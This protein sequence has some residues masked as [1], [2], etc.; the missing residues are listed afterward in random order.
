MIHLL[1]RRFVAR[2]A[3]AALVGVWA[4]GAGP[5]AT[6]QGSGAHAAK[7][8]HIRTEIREAILK[9][10]LVGASVGIAQHGTVIW[11]EGLGWADRE[12][13]IPAT[14]DTTY[15]LASIS[16]TFTATG[17]MILK[18]RGRIGL[19]DPVEK[20]LG[21]AQLTAYRGSTAD[22]TI[23]RLLN[24][25]AGL[26]S[27]YQFFYVDQPYRRPP[28]E[29]SIRR[30]GMLV[31]APG[32]RHT[33]SNFGYGILDHVIARVSGQSY[34]DFMRQEVF[35][36]L[37]MT[38]SSIDI[39]PGLD[40]YVAQRYETDGT[41]I[42]FYDFDHPGASAVYASA[43]DLLRF[44]MFHLKNRLPDQR[45]ILRD[46]T[47]DLMQADSVP[48]GTENERRALGWR[49]EENVG[50][51]RNV[52]HAGGMPGVNTVLRLVPEQNLAVVVLCNYRNSLYGELAD[53][54]VK[55]LVSDYPVRKPEPF[56]PPI[57]TPF[58]AT[59]EL[60][61]AWEGELKAFDVTM[62]VRMT[63]QPDHDIHMKL[64]GGLETLLNEVRFDGQV[65]SA[66]FAG[67]IPSEDIDR[68][69]HDLALNVR[70][71][72]SEMTGTVTA[73]TTTPRQYYSL[74]TWVRLARQGPAVSQ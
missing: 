46:E 50:R 72:G 68:H 10:Q 65:L 52:S 51:Y 6:P 56:P 69:R 71:R 37:G 17:I 73:R 57:R 29:E 3:L 35:L 45:A 34:A 25:T 33:Y 58:K 27:H 63:V 9:G 23:R 43:R 61:G 13:R 31:N 67:T 64:G 74:P 1:R 11:E 16:K 39:G 19:D 30:Y 44:G 48:T 24:H 62:P 38:H 42:P 47:I 60:T 12:R 36:P 2:V 41:P 15:S 26:P 7:F 20:Y 54:I 53:K 22:A 18:D 28:M 59:P 66:R 21:S 70:L 5:A 8:E 14:P 32:E 55:T 49:I 40:S 4:I